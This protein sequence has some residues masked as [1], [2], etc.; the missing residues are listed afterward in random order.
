MTKKHDQRQVGEFRQHQVGL[1]IDEEDHRPILTPMIPTTPHY[2]EALTA[3]NRRK[4]HIVPSMRLA[5]SGESAHVVTRRQ[6]LLTPMSLVGCGPVGQASGRP[7][8]REGCVH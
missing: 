4:V 3:S 1:Y 8:E 5:S 2:A 6:L 7:W